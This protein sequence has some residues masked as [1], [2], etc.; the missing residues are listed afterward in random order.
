MRWEGLACGS[1][2]RIRPDRDGMGESASGRRRLG[3]TL[4]VRRRGDRLRGVTWRC[5]EGVGSG[6]GKAGGGEWVSERE[7]RGRRL[8]GWAKGGEHAR[9]GSIPGAGVGQHPG[10]VSEGGGA[11]S[12]RGERSW[13]E[14]GGTKATVFSLTHKGRRSADSDWRRWITYRLRG[15]VFHVEWV[16]EGG[17]PGMCKE[18]CR[19]SE[20]G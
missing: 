11:F 19:G 18:I 8:Y 7:G 20:G 2:E 13:R 12:E 10:T 3:Y 9:A 4:C 14:L 6:L 15:G 17:C 1:W 5:G 16:R